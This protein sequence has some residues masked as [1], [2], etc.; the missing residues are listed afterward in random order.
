MIREGF[1]A[2]YR[3]VGRFAA[4][5]GFGIMQVY[6]VVS[7]LAFFSLKGPYDAVEEPYLPVMAL[8]T[9]LLSSV[10][11]V[12]LI[13][14]HAYAAPEH[15]VYS[16]MALAFAILLAGITSSVNFA[17]FVVSRQAI[18]ASAPWHSVFLPYRWPTMA[19]A[20]DLFAWDWFYSL[21]VLSAAV[22]FT[23]GPLERVTRIVMVLS[24]WLSL[25]GLTAMP[26]APTVGIGFSI[27]GWGV[28]GSLVLLLWAIVFGRTPAVNG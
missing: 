17:V 8:L 24:G 12:T 23:K 9:I 28:C 1:S 21:A 14:V 7:G 11:V 26:F 18:E 10:M 20:M 27:V 22:V 3:K 16:F 2:Q 6:S 5:T 4:W 15:R 13:A 19:Y 25:I